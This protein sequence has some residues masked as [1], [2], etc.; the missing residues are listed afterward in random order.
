MKDVLETN[1]REIVQQYKMTMTDQFNKLKSR[2]QEAQNKN[3][4]LDDNIVSIT[5]KLEEVTR[6]KVIIIF[7]FFI[8]SATRLFENRFNSIYW[9]FLG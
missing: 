6:E 3:I 7:S 1:H 4:V 5:Q 8:S 9:H 2:L